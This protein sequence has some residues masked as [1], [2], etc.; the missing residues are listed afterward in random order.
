MAL[1]CSDERL[2]RMHPRSILPTKEPGTEVDHAEADADQPATPGKAHDEGPLRPLGRRADEGVVVR[3]AA[4]DSVHDDS[5]CR[6]NVAAVGGDVRHDVLGAALNSGV[7]PELTR[8]L[9]VV[10]R[11]LDVDRALRP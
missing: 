11:K 7:A 1:C 3:V 10:R 9:L 2:G 6:R 5:V 8:Y 4:D